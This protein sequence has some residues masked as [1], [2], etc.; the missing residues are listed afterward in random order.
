MDFYGSYGNAY[1]TVKEFQPFDPRHDAEVLRKAMKGFGTDEQAIIDVLA[2]RTNAQRQVISE[3]YK[4]DFGRDLVDDLKSE[5]SGNFEDAIK[6]LMT[7]TVEYLTKQIHKAVSGIGTDEDSL[8]EILVTC[9]NQQ[10]KDLDECYQRLYEKNLEDALTSDTSGHFRR[11]LVSLCSANRDENAAVRRDLVVE[12]AQSLFEAGENKWGT[13]E[14]VF[15]KIFAT[16]S[17]NHLK[18][19]FEEYLRQTGNTIEHSIENE[20]SDDLQMGLLSI[21]KCVQNVPGFLA[22]RLYQSM[23]GA[24]TDDRTLIRIITTRSENDMVLVKQEFEKAYGQTLEHHIADETS[25]DYKRILLGLCQPA[26]A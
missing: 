6:A 19:V 5:L 24:G 13:D 26:F 8:V 17:R 14:S 18:A 11:L 12:D 25:G 3:A 2:N 10:I 16:R 23:K 1:A 7:P 4:T 20:T 22:E 21:V 9:N 15:N